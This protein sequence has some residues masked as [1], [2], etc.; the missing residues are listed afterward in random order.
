[1]LVE[2]VVSAVPK[3]GP[4]DVVHPS[5]RRSEM[6]CW[7]M[8]IFLELLSQLLCTSD[9]LLGLFDFVGHYFTPFVQNA[10][11]RSLQTSTNPALVI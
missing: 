4:I 3:E 7:S 6:I 11:L 10:D 1:M 9:E 5:P 8:G 2:N